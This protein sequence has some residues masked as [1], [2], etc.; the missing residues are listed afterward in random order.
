MSNLWEDLVERFQDKFHKAAL[1]I[2]TGSFLCEFAA[3]Q[4]KKNERKHENVLGEE[5]W[6]SMKY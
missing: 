6:L 5:D 3:E 2:T 4:K 1:R